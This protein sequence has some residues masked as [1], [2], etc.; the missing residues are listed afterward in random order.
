MNNII[1]RLLFTNIVLG[2]I[3]KLS[4]SAGL[5]TKKDDVYQNYILPILN[6]YTKK[7]KIDLNYDFY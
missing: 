4:V 2:D 3:Y 7:N 6:D 5:T 1:C